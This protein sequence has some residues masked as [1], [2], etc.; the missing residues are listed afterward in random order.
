MTC[1]PEPPL[2]LDAGQEQAPGRPKEVSAHRQG[3]RGQQLLKSPSVPGDTLRQLSV[4]QCC[5][6]IMLPTL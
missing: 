5:S 2:L 1:N 3:L 4:A 6:D